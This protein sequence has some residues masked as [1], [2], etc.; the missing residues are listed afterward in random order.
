MSIISHL[1]NQKWFMC[2]RGRVTV[3]YVMFN[4]LTISALYTQLSWKL[5]IGLRNSLVHC[6]ANIDRFP[7]NLRI[8]KSDE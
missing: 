6:E 8:F 2:G 4:M 5:L 3:G 7:M 1:Y